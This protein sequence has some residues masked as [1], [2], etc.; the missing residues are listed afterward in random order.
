[1]LRSIGAVLAGLVVTYA[2][3]IAAVFVAAS[4]LAGVVY[5]VANLAISVVAGA[6]GGYVAALTAARAP[7]SHGAALAG[8]IVGLGILSLLA[9]ADAHPIWYSVATPSLGVLGA[10]AGAWVRSRRLFSTVKS[11]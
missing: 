10:L 1:M 6:C 7:L 2:V 5:V 8:L 4:T 9:S 11:I 3:V